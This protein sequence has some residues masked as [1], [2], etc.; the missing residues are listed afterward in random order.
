MLWLLLATALATV[1]EKYG[2]GSRSMGLG[3][4]GV[5]WVHDG[6]AALLNPAGLS[7]IRRPMAGAGMSAAVD[8]F[9]PLPSVWWDTNRD[10]TIDERDPPLQLS[11]DVENAVGVHFHASRH[12]GGKFG[13]GLV[14]YVPTQRVIQLRS[15][16]PDLPEYT[17]YNSRQQ[18]YV[19]AAG[20]G[21]E[22]LNGV[23]VGIG[24]DFVPRAIVSVAFTVNA[25][26]VGNDDD[27]FSDVVTGVV[28]DLHELQL[29]LVAGFA[30]T[31][32]VTL[33]LG[34]WSE[35]LQGASI[36]LSYH[37]SSGLPV[38]SE[39]DAQFGVSVED[40]G[41][42]DPY[43][44]AAAAQAGLRLY[45]HY[46]PTTV[47]LGLSYMPERR[48]GAAVDLTWTNWQPLALSVARLTEA[49]IDSPIVRLEDEVVDG[50]AFEATFRNTVTV[51]TGVELPLRTI[52]LG[53]KWRYADI[54]FRLGGG[55]AP[56]PLVDQGPSSAF[57]DTNRLY[58]TAGAGLETWDPTGLLDGASRIDLMSQ[59]HILEAGLLPRASDE[60]RSGYPVARNDIPYGGSIWV[61]GG[62][63]SFEF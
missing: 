48:F 34:A 11:S 50:N 14:G 31:A 16:E 8:R 15:S 23:H 26:V 56:T 29:D 20:V 53:E 22:V 30:P 59:V 6:H 36:G 44:L 51:R 13:L 12:I 25:T 39:L 58:F 5:S 32:G 42:L 9:Q 3:G 1:P 46:V 40:V 45:D 43:V 7:R 52:E 61:F 24:V 28:V 41:D 33:D 17:F 37:G 27:D 60:P 62:Q 57:I 21:G 63:W 55:Y 38:D 54:A 10:G 35:P 4:T 18:R 49:N 19:L 2:T 47:S